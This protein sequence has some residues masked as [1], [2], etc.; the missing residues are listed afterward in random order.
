ML[1]GLLSNK[2]V[3]I[4]IIS[5]VVTL[6]IRKILYNWIDKKAKT[7][8]T[9]LDDL[10]VQTTKMSSFLWCFVIALYLAMNISKLDVEYRIFINKILVG[11]I[12]LSFTI[13]IANV[14]TKMVTFYAK[15]SGL[16]VHVS[17]LSQSI[18]RILVVTIGILILMNYLGIPIT[19]LITAMGI[20]GLAVALALQ[21]SLTN[22][23]SG[24]HIILEQPLKIGDYVRLDS[25]EEG[26]V[27]DIGWRT[28]RIRA[29]QNNMI[30]IPNKRLAESIIT[31]FYLPQK[32]MAVYIKVG[33]SYDCDPE[34]IEQILL[35]EASKA[36]DEIR[37]MRKDPA[38]IVRFSPGFGDFS[39]DFTLICYIEEFIDQYRI[40]HEL[41][42]KIFKRLK[43]EGIEIP[44]PIQTIYMKQNSDT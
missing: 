34:Q 20:G 6:L 25:G 38:P 42:K 10:I 9:N 11:L 36:I 43:Q 21:D 19:P 14:L 29:I 13:A 40:Q 26:Y 28:T 37:G 7:T 12:I 3:I 23:F 1:N 8:E 27:T 2:P 33:V 32:R 22:F 5:L 41:R 44:F 31:N 39:L 35:D 16:M 18:T 24:I 15:R 30:I 4:F 17:G